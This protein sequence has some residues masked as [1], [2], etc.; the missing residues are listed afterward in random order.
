ML[1][2]L[3]ALALIVIAIYWSFSSLMPS[4][5]SGLSAEENSFS[6]E[7]ALVH[8]AAI[9]QKPHYVGSPEHAN[10]RAYI[11]KQLEALGLET[12][13]QE[14]YTI[15]RWGN[16]AKPKNILARIKG[17]E[18][19]KALMLLSH[20]DSNPHS[21]LGASDA[22]SGV[23]TIL[24]GLRAYLSE[25]K[26]PKNDLIICIT[27]A[28]EI[29][30][31]GA[32]L[33]VNQHPWAK[34]VGLVLNFEARGSGG[35]SYMLI[36]T[37]G[38]NTN[39]MKEFVEANPGFPVANSLAYSIYKML[40]ND[41]D[42]TIFRRDGDI[43]GFN[44]AFIDDHY[45]YHSANDTYER[46]D[47]NTLE[48]QGSYLMP[49]L[50]HFSEANLSNL[51]SQNDDIYV[52]MPLFGMVTYPF[53]WIFPMLFITT[54]LFLSLLFYGIKKRKLEG[55][56]IVRGFIPL[57][58]SL[59]SVI[60]LGYALWELL[61]SIYPGYSE[62]E[63]GFTYNGHTYIAAFT[64]L[65]LAICLW[66]YHKFYRPGNTGSLLVAPLVLWILISAI[67][68]MKLQGASFF[69]IPVIFG[70]IGLFI[71]IQQKEPSLVLMALLSFPVLFIMSPLVKMFPVGLGFYLGDSDG[72]QFSMKI[73]SMI[74]VVLIFGLLL[75]V[76]GFLKHKK[77]WS[78]GV[79][80]ITIILL[81]SAHFNSSFT[82]DNPKPNSLVYSLNA[83][84]NTAI[85]ATYDQL[86]DDWTRNFLGDDPDIVNENTDTFASK[87]GSGYTFTKSAPVKEIQHPY[88]EIK[89]DT[90]VGDLRHINMYISQQRPVNRMELFADRSIVFK[91]FNINGVD[92]YKKNDNANAFDNRWRNRLFSFYVSDNDPLIL[93][94]SVPKEQKTI[95]TLYEASF[96][97]LGNAQFTVPKRQDDMI[98]K[99]FVLNDA[100]L[101]K[102][103]I[104]ID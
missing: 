40:P 91:D 84:D 33:F 60:I 85:W 38:G 20:Y 27:D 25:G 97:L 80:L 21:S 51:K 53:A 30:L 103:T 95:F 94:F 4:S 46:L 22:G 52:N 1:K 18:T 35:P 61:K 29:G 99:P 44:F 39:L 78:Y 47:R 36:E 16:M 101:V 32:D 66:I 2:K 56:E 55:P 9:S 63:H 102:K 89:T 31:N 81:L 14:G 83:D 72:T 49:L 65:A 90:V 17:R 75:P 15:S 10:V 59:V 45:D 67:V 42:L 86:L 71:L 24:E 37:N 92:V 50:R 88:V 87:Y 77:R 7:R 104:T 73:V 69:I 74:L 28:E 23:V 6:T 93:T 13:I 64:F 41:T 19:G 100:I 79:L 68:A 3:V 26:T 62:M 5:I 58:V 96:D 70:L 8:L 82:K 48:H 12:W 57:L 11:V 43:E 98:P 54:I 76:F 34:E